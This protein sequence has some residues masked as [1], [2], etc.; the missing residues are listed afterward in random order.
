M[1]KIPSCESGIDCEKGIVCPS[2]LL[3]EMFIVK[4]ESLT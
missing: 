3:L 1:L 2:S 4:D